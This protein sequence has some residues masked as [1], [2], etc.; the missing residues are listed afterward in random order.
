M[1]MR[2][3]REYLEN[4]DGCFVLTTETYVH[5]HLKVGGSKQDDQYFSQNLHSMSCHSLEVELLSNPVSSFQK[6]KV[7]KSLNE[8][9]LVFG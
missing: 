1:D 3:R 7:Y 5:V 4:D 6:Q 9:T 8:G 2:M